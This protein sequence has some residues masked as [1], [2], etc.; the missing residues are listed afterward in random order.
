VAANACLRDKY[1]PCPFFFILLRVGLC[2]ICKRN[3]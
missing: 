2:K 3:A 1:R